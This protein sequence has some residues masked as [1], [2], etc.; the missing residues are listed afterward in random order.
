MK[1]GLVLEGGAMRGM[2]SCGVCDVLLENGVEFDG[3]IGTSAGAVFGCNYKSKQIGRAIRYN[4]KYCNDKRFASFENRIKTGSFYSKEF[5]YNKLVHELDPF[6]IEEYSSNNM[7]FYVTCTEAKTGEAVYFNCLKGDEEDLEY[8]R[9]SAA[10]PILSQPVKIGNY[11]LLDGGIADSVPIQ[12]ME[13]LGYDKNVV[14]L[15]QPK[16]F[17]KQPI[18]ILPLLNIALHKYPNTVNALKN[19][20]IEYNDTTRYI[21]EKEQ[22][23]ELLVIRP[24]EALNIK[25][26]T[27]SAD[28][29]KRVYDIG[30]TVGK[31]NLEKIKEYLS[32]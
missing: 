2:F 29:L 22:R 3:A 1:K 13:S 6:D 24:P 18:K 25:S 32:K 12:K 9:G 27:K 15:T 4:M 26:F 28:E 10:M 16:G 30:I 11:E 7:D 21:E 14:I 8:M 17:V 20:H 5:A 31:E 23:G 19:R